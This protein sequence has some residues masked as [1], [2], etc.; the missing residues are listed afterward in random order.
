MMPHRV[1]TAGECLDNIVDDQRSSGM[2]FACVL[3]IYLERDKGYIVSLEEAVE[4]GA[5]LPL[6][7]RPMTV[8]SVGGKPH[9]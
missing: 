4:D 3:D 1:M 6:Q 2:V 7:L 9:R 8:D 5:H